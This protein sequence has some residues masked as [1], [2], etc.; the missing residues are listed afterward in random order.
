MDSSEIDE[1]FPVFGP[2]ALHA[3][4]A[5]QRT[6]M[7][8]NYASF[9]WFE[10]LYQT[11]P[12]ASTSQALRVGTGT[13]WIMHVVNE[14]GTGLWDLSFSGF[15]P[16]DDFLEPY[17]VDSSD[18]FF[19]VNNFF[20]P[21]PSVASIG[22]TSCGATTTSSNSFVTVSQTL[23]HPTGGPLTTG[24]RFLYPS[25]EYSGAGTSWGFSHDGRAIIPG[26]HMTRS[27]SLIALT[28]NG[29][30]SLDM[31]RDDD[32]LYNASIKNSSLL[33]LSPRVEDWLRIPLNTG[34]YTT[35]TGSGYIVSG[36]ANGIQTWVSTTGFNM[37]DYPSH[38]KVVHSG[39]PYLDFKA[40]RNGDYYPPYYIRSGIFLSGWY[41]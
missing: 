11:Q 27:T 13:G 20:M 10:K 6:N 15:R 18:R 19:Y 24:F 12:Q 39:L 21:Y 1:H 22:G 16:Q 40:Q 41:E 29:T 34:R 28:D 35:I 9:V 33:P 30:I 23:T 4:E 5:T 25:V 7:S 14:E 32:G 37:A 3:T 26:G 8:G 2:F 36:C 38:Y 17:V 31:Y